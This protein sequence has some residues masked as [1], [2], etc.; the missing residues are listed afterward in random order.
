MRGTGIIPSFSDGG[1]S[2]SRQWWML[3]ATD[4]E[5]WSLVA[6]GNKLFTFNTA[7]LF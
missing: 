7:H 1:T 5:G 3:V 6:L 4:D 2:G